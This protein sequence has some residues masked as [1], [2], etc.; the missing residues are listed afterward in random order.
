VVLEGFAAVDE[1]DGDFIGKLPAELVV[2]VHVDVLP[3]EAA[4]ALQL[5]E[6]LFDDFAEVAAFAR[7]NHDL[8]EFRH[9]GEF[10][11][12]GCVVP[13]GWWREAMGGELT[14]CTRD[15]S[16]TFIRFRMTPW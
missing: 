12:V 1:N 15:P 3:G 6:G 10:S 8:A 4:P 2:G 14:P 5:G 9:C 11:K 13:V 16:R 7:V